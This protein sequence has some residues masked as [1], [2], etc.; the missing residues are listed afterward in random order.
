MDFFS[1]DM[2]LGAV[3]SIFIPDFFIILIQLLISEKLWLI[4]SNIGNGSVKIF[5]IHFQKHR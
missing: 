2:E 5:K 3:E 1:K 4:S